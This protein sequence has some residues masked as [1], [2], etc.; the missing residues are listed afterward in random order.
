MP[1]ITAK[2]LNGDLVQV[3]LQEPTVFLFRQAAGDLLEV[4]PNVIT[5]IDPQ[6]EER[7]SDN[8]ILSADEIYFIVIREVTQRGA[9]YVPPEST[10]LLRKPSGTLQAMVQRQSRHIEK[11][12]NEVREIMESDLSDVQK[13]N[14]T[15]DKR[16]ELFAMAE[17]LT[18]VY[19]ELLRREPSSVEGYDGTGLLAFIK[20]LLRLFIF[21]L[22]FILPGG[23]K[24][25]DK[26]AIVLEYFLGGVELSMRLLIIV[27]PLL[28]L[29][30]LLFESL[31]TMPVFSRQE[32]REVSQVQLELEASYNHMMD[33]VQR[34]GTHDCSICYNRY[35]PENPKVHLPECGHAFHQE[36]IDRLFLSQRATGQ[37]RRCPLCMSATQGN[38][39]RKPVVGKLK[40]SGKM[41]KY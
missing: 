34:A 40:F 15:K 28:Q 18:S 29:S 25:V 30:E 41:R 16:E 23:L 20:L 21:Y 17:T 24:P 10:V 7:M 13:D 39:Q 14:R 27:R 9:R 3:D 36:C 4:R 35:T 1:L 19:A 33:M 22:G 8:D 12:S 11:L 31:A 6:T 38:Y 37:P 32:Q 26:E 5:V 2:L